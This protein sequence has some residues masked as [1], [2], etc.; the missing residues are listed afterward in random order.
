MSCND[1]F[2][3]SLCFQPQVFG[4]RGEAGAPV[5][6][7]AMAANELVHACAVEAMTAKEEVP[8]PKNVTMLYVR[9]QVK[10]IVVCFGS[11]TFCRLNNGRKNRGVTC[12]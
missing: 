4:L 5:Q 6:K 7:L 8:S 1:F 3:F 9:F 2:F 11:L 12:R 10:E